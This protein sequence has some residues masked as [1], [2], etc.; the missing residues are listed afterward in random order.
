MKA[1]AI[2]NVNAF[3]QKMVAKVINPAA[4]INNSL[5]SFSSALSSGLTEDVVFASPIGLATEPA[6]CSIAVFIKILF[7]TYNYKHKFNYYLKLFCCL[8]RHLGKTGNNAV[9]L[10]AQFIQR[11]FAA[12]DPERAESEMGRA[13][14]VPAIRRHETNFVGLDT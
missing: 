11:L 10:K 2:V 14:Y 7:D 8:I 5:E 12:I 3:L 9:G 1:T 4:K 6:A 13:H